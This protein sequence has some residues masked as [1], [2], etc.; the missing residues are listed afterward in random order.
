VTD[1]NLAVA[2]DAP[3]ATT[4]T[5]SDSVFLKGMTM[6][7]KLASLML[8]ILSGYCSQAAELR[9]AGVLGNSGGSGETRAAFS[10][11]LA[12]GMG[13]VLDESG[14]IWER[15]GSDQL[16]RYALDGRML[17]TFPLPHGTSSKDQLTLASGM[18]LI[19]INKSLYKLAANS[20]PGTSPERVD[21]PATVIA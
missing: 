3:Y 7:R 16:N 13:P 9:F 4:K 15:G 11:K 20:P 21:V 12:P 19:N 6:V 18:L 1:N 10:G 14:T 2:V 17:A 8:L 5:E